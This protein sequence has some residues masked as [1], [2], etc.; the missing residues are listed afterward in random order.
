MS[1]PISP[2]ISEY[3][4]ELN[5]RNV[6]YGYDNDYRLTSEAI[7]G[8][9]GGN[10]G[11]VSYTG[12]D[13]VGNRTQMTSTLGAVP[14]GSF[15]YDSN[16][17]LSGPSYDNNGNTI[18]R[19]RSRVMTSERRLLG[20]DGREDAEDCR[21]TPI[22]SAVREEFLL[23]PEIECPFSVDWHTWPSHFLYYPQIRHLIGPGEPALIE[24]DADCRGGL[25]LSLERMRR[26]LSENRRNA[27]AVAIEV[28]SPDR[29]SLDEFPSPLV[30]SQTEPEILPAG[31]ALL[32]FDVADSGFCSALSNCGYS[33]DERNELRPQ[34]QSR[35]NDFGL[36]KTQE[37]AIEFKEVSDRRVIEHAPFWVYRLHR[38]ANL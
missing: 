15:F 7:T 38:L 2:D 18:R 35:I 10:N 30:Y 37:A 14:G 22:P 34:W 36:L 17:R 13:A 8:D 3:V 33:V 20:F 9:P 1:A 24:T 16:D 26:R 31:S 4:L 23:R 11:T 29:A 21:K 27:V 32:G 5:S 25:W 19:R 6:G 28:F 12:Y